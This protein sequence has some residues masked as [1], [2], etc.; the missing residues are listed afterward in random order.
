MTNN[1]RDSLTRK[2]V[3][4]KT[5]EY[6]EGWDK[7]IDSGWDDFDNCPYTDSSENKINWDDGYIDSLENMGLIY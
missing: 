1:P 7:A 2:M 6:Q 4:N 3:I 5:K